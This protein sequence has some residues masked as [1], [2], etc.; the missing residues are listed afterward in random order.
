ML[1]M[2]K[3]TYIS[4]VIIALVSFTFATFAEATPLRKH[5]SEHR[6]YGTHQKVAQ[7]RITASQA[8][9]IARQRV[10]DAQ[11]ID[12]MLNGNVYKVRMQ[13]KNGRV[14]DIN[15][16]ATTGRVR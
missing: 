8:K 2:R 14:V 16:D 1:I 10:R 6:S 4:I 5:K 7:K 15:V 11:V 12:V 9:S 3:Y 13:K